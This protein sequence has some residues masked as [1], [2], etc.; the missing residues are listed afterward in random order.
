MSS[1]SEQ[2][3]IHP[4]QAP[5]PGVTVQELERMSD[6]EF[7]NYARLREQTRPEPPSHTEYIEC[8]LSTHACLIA[9]HD[10]A[11]ILPP[12]HRLARLPNMPAW[13]AGIMAWRGETIA[14]V[15]LALYLLGAQQSDASW[16]ADSMLL[17][18][19]QNGIVMGLL[20]PALGFTSTITQEQIISSNAF[21]GFAFTLDPDLVTGTHADLPILTISTLLTQLEQQIGVA[22]YHE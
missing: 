7:W 12:P 18:A 20:V 16:A 3:N 17:V 5:V 11:E 22:E 2:H 6:E 13:M 4:R 1:S 14:V 9:F 15:N 21:R 10:L 8:K 19:S